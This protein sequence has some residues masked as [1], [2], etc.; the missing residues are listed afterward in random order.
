MT[1]HELLGKEC[2]SFTEWHKKSNEIGICEK[3]WHECDWHLL[4]D[5]MDRA[6]DFLTQPLTPEW[7]EKYIE[8][9]ELNR[10][11]VHYYKSSDEWNLKGTII[12]LK[13]PSHLF[14]SLPEDIKLTY[15]NVEI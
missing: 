8:C 14:E 5:E 2:M 9:G 1:T 6:R 12:K 4:L 10:I 11:G 7:M 3:H 13:H 15:K